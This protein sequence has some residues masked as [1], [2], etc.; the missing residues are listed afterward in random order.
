MSLFHFYNRK[1]KT[2]CLVVVCSWPN[3]IRF[4]LVHLT[5]MLFF[6]Y[7]FFVL[8][9]FPPSTIYFLDFSRYFNTR[10]TC[11][12]HIK[13]SF[14]FSFKQTKTLRVKGVD[15]ANWVEELNKKKHLTWL[16]RKYSLTKKLVVCLW[17]FKFNW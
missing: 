3:S 17:R 1:E 12:I 16:I 4:F 9:Q 13:K 10:D 8:N 7:I 11:K 2:F 15:R 14:N 6:L 5:L